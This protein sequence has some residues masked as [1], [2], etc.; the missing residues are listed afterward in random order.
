MKAMEQS[1]FLLDQLS[2]PEPRTKD[3]L[4]M[5]NGLAVD[6]S[7]LIVLPEPDHMVSKSAHNLP[8]IQALPVQSLNSLDVMRHHFLVMPVDAARKIEATLSLSGLSLASEVEG[9]DE[10]A[11]PEA[12]LDRVEG[13][14]P[15]ATAEVPGEGETEVAANAETGSE[16]ES[17]QG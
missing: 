11:E 8:D 13:E 17:E 1:L 16:T 14:G 12:L 4:N 2:L 3:I 5:L 10:S 15:E 9:K 7:T 6:R